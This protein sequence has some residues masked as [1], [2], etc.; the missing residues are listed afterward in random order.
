[1]EGC[2]GPRN[3]MY[4]VLGARGELP[5]EPHAGCDALPLL[6]GKEHP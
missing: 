1:M 3:S 5:R 2:C 6:E 4:K